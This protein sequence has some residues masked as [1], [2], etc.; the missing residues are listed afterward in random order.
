MYTCY[1]MLTISCYQRQSPSTNLNVHLSC[2]AIRENHHIQNIMYTWYFLLSETIT[3]LTNFNVHL[4]FPVNRD[5]HLL[6]NI[7]YTCL[8]MLSEII[9]FY[10]LSMTCYLRLSP[11][12][13]RNISYIYLMTFPQMHSL[14]IGKLFLN[15]DTIRISK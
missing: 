2:Y 15:Q 1:V 6:P 14:T 9:N 13:I 7:M 3:C 5:N 4:P 10:Q 8:V 11:S 12:I